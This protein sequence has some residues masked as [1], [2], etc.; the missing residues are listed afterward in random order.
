VHGVSGRVAV[1]LFNLGGPDKPEAIRPFLFNLFNDPAIINLPGP[2]RTPL[3]AFIAWR[4]APVAK[5]IYGH[6]GGSSPLLALT[7]QQA[8]ECVLKSV[9]QNSCIITS[10]LHIKNSPV[11]STG[12]DTIRHFCA[13]PAKKCASTPNFRRILRSIC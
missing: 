5:E 10:H 6:I 7:E 1:V 9:H 13:T 3:A 11:Q 12:W 4:R 8:A 2:L